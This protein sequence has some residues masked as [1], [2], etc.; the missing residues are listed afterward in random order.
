LPAFR[1]AAFHY[2]HLFSLPHWAP[3]SSSLK[4]RLLITIAAFSE[5]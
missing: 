2:G 3:L 5:R 1:F 4:F